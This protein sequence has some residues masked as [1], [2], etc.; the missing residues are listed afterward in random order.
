LAAKQT[1]ALDA[2]GNAIAAAAGFLTSLNNKFLFICFISLPRNLRLNCRPAIGQKND[3]RLPE[4]A[5]NYRSSWSTGLPGMGRT[6][7]GEAATCS[8]ELSDSLWVEC[9]SR[10]V[11]RNVPH[12]E[13][14]STV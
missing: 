3:Y 12:L 10:C 13:G 2:N 8:A 9:F 7:C 5:R 11:I 6:G 14:M 4:R 1:V